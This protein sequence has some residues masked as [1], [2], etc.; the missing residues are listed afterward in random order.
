M[1]VKA[2]TG[3]ASPHTLRHSFA[4]HMV[5]HGADLRS[6]QILLG[7]A[8]ISTTEV[9]T[10][11]ALGRLKAVHREHHPRGLRRDIE[12]E[13][14]REGST[15]EPALTQSATNPAAGDSPQ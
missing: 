2:A 4:T 12:H 3:G 14:E 11:V 10:H 7:H 5:D 9:Y 6:V 1:V 8:D 13:A 15:A